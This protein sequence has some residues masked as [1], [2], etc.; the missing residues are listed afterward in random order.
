MTVLVAL[1]RGGGLAAACVGS[2]I[3]RGGVPCTEDMALDSGIWRGL[4]QC[5]IRHAGGVDVLLAVAGEAAEPVLA[6]A[7]MQALTAMVGS[8]EARALLL[9]H[10]GF[11]DSLLSSMH[12]G[13]PPC[14]S[15]ALRCTLP[16]LACARD[17]I[18]PDI[19]RLCAQSGPS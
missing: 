9:Q 5:L 2:C 1:C 18:A 10:P 12:T 11:L 15:A 14:S 13:M 16:L 17:A 6:A 7:A 8:A 3:S 19:C 4:H